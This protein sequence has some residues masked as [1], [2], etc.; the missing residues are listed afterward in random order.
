MS[1]DW[2][3][4]PEG[5]ALLKETFANQTEEEKRGK[6]PGQFEYPDIEVLTERKRMDI[7]VIG[8]YFS[9]AS[10]GA[11][12]GIIAALKGLG[13]DVWICDPAANRMEYPS[14]TGT[15]PNVDWEALLARQFD[16]VLI[17]GPGLPPASLKD[18]KCYRNIVNHKTVCW[19]SEPIRLSHYKSRV[20]EQQ[21]LIDEWATFDEGEVHL[22]EA[23]GMKAFFLPQAFNPEWYRPLEDVQPN[24]YACFVGSIGGKW[25]NRSIMVK[26]LKRVFGNDFYVAR[27]FDAK[28]V[29][30]I[31]NTYAIVMN[32]GL[33]HENLGP[34]E[35]L[36]SY[37]F[38]QRI[39][40]AIGA[41]AVPCTNRPA[42]LDNTPQQQAMFS[43][44]QNIIYY[45]N[46]NLEAILKF[47]ATNPEK[48]ADIHRQVL[49]IRGQHIYETRMKELLDRYEQNTNPDG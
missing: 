10:H 29:N 27:T 2:E 12:P 15:H 45:T 3:I 48:L 37:A 31:Y 49:E 34:P 43:N 23:M 9:N 25:A 6:F 21:E 26:R 32:L 14:H 39:F 40:E 28:Q 22:Y 33:Y 1:N 13:H 41:G 47:Y 30:Q 20:E 24:G 18:P 11:E 44:G 46:E 17:V 38:Q 16:L 36:G 5:A 8:K 7:C 35:R 42:D 4:T 19:N